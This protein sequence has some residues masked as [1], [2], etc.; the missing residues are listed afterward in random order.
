MKRIGVFPGSFDPF[1]KGHEDIVNRFLPLFDEVII[2]IGVN[3]SKKYMHSLDSRITHIQS[4]FAGE[5]KVSVDCYSKLTV[6][7]C[8]EK[9]AQYC[10]LVFWL[11]RT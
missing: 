6:D 11:Q 8:K 1:T 5:E 7:F 4:L 3:D 2:A 10:E 9:G